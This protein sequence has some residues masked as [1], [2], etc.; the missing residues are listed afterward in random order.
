METG[1]PT[2]RSQ[3]ARQIAAMPMDTTEDNQHVSLPPLAYR[4]PMFLPPPASLSQQSHPIALPPLAHQ[5]PTFTQPPALIGPEQYL[6]LPLPPQQQ[7]LAL[8]APQQQLALDH[9]GGSLAI[10]YNPR[11]MKRTNVNNRVDKRKKVLLEDERADAVKRKSEN[12]GG[13]EKKKLVLDCG[14]RGQLI[15]E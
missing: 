14:K 5:Q 7:Q 13:Q 4:Q 1:E 10:E 2:Y 15:W 11:G 9:P 6:A 12:D 3:Y 8:S